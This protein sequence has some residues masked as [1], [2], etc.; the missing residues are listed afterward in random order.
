[1][2]GTDSR[3]GKV[4][5]ERFR[6][7]CGVQPVACWE[8]LKSGKLRICEL[9]HPVAMNTTRS[10]M[11]GSKDCSGSCGSQAR[12]LNRK[13]TQVLMEVSI[14]KEWIWWDGA[15]GKVASAAGET[16]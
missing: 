14:K 5:F 8:A 7:P 4:R 2:C 9:E 12:V 6:Q 13:I 15:V 16:A 10:H 1:M 11:G 3:M